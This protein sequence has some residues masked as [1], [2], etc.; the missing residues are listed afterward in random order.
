MINSFDCE[1]QC[2]SCFFID[3]FVMYEKGG[4]K[5]KYYFGRR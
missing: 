2:F 1:A 5:I 4:T 3:N